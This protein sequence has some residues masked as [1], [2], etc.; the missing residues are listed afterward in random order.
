MSTYVLIHGGAHGGWCWNL[1]AAELVA[2]GHEVVAPDLPIDDEIST[3]R[4]QAQ[5]VVDAV[6]SR[7]DCVVVAHSLGGLVGPIVASLLDDVQLLVLVAAMVPSP[8]ETCLE[9]WAATGYEPPI[10]GAGDD[11]RA[12]AEAVSALESGDTERRLAMP[13]A[14][15][16]A[17][18]YHDVPPGLAAEAVVH[19]RSQA[20]AVFAEPWPLAAWPAVPTRYLL[21][22]DDRVVPPEWSRRVVAER[23]GIVADEIDGSHSPFLSRP[24]E[25]ADMLELWRASAREVNFT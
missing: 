1:L 7:R 24:A 22:R 19:L 17:S 5:T 3:L 18:F 9:L 14:A 20:A 4:D 21:C 13:A 2:H 15:A 6:G 16:I 11:D 10:G 23:L 12:V 8:G 25:L